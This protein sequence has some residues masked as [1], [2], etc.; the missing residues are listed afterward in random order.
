[1]PLSRGVLCVLTATAILAAG[2]FVGAQREITERHVYISVAGSKG[3]PPSLTPKDIIV[4]EDDVA[5]E[6]IRVGPAPPPTHLVLLVDHTA[7]AQTFLQELR[8]GLIAV[9]RQMS[10]LPTPPQ[11]MLMSVA[12]RPAR[13]V[14]F[15]TSD[16]AIENAVKRIFPRP[17]S[18]AYFLDGVAEASA[19][20][21][22][23]GAERPAILA[24]VMEA[25]PEFSNR[26]HRSVAD[27]LEDA[28]ASLWTITMQEPTPGLSLAARERASV[29]G[30]VTGWSGGMNT[31][32]LSSNGLAGAFASTAAALLGRL[33]VTY[34]RPAALIPPSRLSVEL[35][36]RSLRVSAPR[37]AGE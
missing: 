8:A 35:R 2:P 10:Q 17:G 26:V 36:D 21:G 31:P 13:L 7:E 18:G 6:V 5:R 34:G 22:R 30:D 14:D 15:T 28:G 23:A 25:S 27:A 37:W 4:R 9:A 33:D 1:M 32:V 12:E 11:M 24:F 29:V 16:I 3:A 20:L 19:A